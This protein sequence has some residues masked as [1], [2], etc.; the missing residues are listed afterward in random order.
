MSGLKT[1]SECMYVVLLISRAGHATDNRY[2]VEMHKDGSDL[3]L[4]E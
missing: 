3:F 2:Y 1:I 4:S